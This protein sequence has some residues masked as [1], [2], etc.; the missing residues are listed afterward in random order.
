MDGYGEE[1]TVTEEVRGKVEQC[2][3]RLEQ[4][5]GRTFSTFNPATCR[6][7]E[8]DGSVFYL[9]I[10]DLDDG[11]KGEVNFRKNPEGKYEV[12]K[13]GLSGD[14]LEVDLV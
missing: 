5:A 10:V 11:I 12:L 7:K 4:H 14:N 3:Q 8:E 2:K 9:V 6:M 13:L 1:L